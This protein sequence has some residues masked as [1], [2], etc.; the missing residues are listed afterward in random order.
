MFEVSAT[1]TE[2]QS[3]LAR[4]RADG[5][6]R[7]LSELVDLVGACQSV[8]NQAAA[9][10]A[11]ALAHVAAI[12]DVALEDGT[13]VEQHRGLGHQRLDAPS[14]VS[15]QLGVS[16][17]VASNRMGTAVE[18]VTRLPGLLTA[19][20]DGRL[21][22]YRARVVGD[23]LRDAPP[24]VC[25]QVVTRIAD[26]L[27]TEPPAMLRRRVRWAL[28]AVDAELLRAKAARAR[29]ERSLCRWP[30][31]EPG[32]DTWMGSFPAEQSRSGWAVVDGLARQYVH[33]GRAG[34]LEQARADALMDLIHA[35]ATGTFVVQLAVPADQLNA[36]TGPPSASTRP[37]PTQPSRSRRANALSAQEQPRP[38]SR[39]PRFSP[40]RRTTSW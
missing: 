10:Q 11:L 26:S 19:M 4:L 12:E 5:R 23:E 20:G 18:V 7:A 16:D 33:E 1:A 31:D 30:G 14:L 39:Q 38:R 2:L 15:D 25:A 27:G 36:T 29:S 13:V 24:E 22:E 32:V 21:D 35:R 8:M 9:V 6:D 3:E 28:G 37:S 17:A 40:L 34:G